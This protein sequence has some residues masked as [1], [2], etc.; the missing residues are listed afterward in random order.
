MQTVRKS[1]NRRAPD[2]LNTLPIDFS[3]LKNR[4]EKKRSAI[5]VPLR[6]CELILF[7]G[8]RREGPTVAQGE[9]WKNT[10][11][12]LLIIREKSAWQRFYFL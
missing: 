4:L 2:V 10:V 3:L 6:D 12:H 5:C 8:G 7:V 1:K 11:L 9:N